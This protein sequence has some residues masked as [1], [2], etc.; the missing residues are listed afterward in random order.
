MN[1]KKI[2]LAIIFGL[3]SLMVLVGCQLDAA[4][5]ASPAPAQSASPAAEA[6]SPAPDGIYVVSNAEDFLA[7]IGPERTICLEA[8]FY[9]L[10]LAESYG[11]GCGENW[12]W[13]ECYD[14]YKLVINGL[15]GL[16]I[17]GSLERTE[18]A[19]QPRYANVLNFENC[20]NITLDSLVLGHTPEPGSCSGGV[21]YLE[22]CSNVRINSGNLYGCGTIG[23]TAINCKA[24]YAADCRIYD[25][26]QNAVLAIASYDVRI[27]NS[28]IHHNGS[29]WCSALFY[30]DNCNGFAIVNCEV[31][32]NQAH[33][34]VSSSYSQQLSILGCNVHTNEFSQSLLN[35]TGYSP[36]VDKCSFGFNG[37]PVVYADMKAVDLDGETISADDLLF[38]EQGKAA[39]SGPRQAKPVELEESVNAEGMREVYVSTVDQFL[40]AIAS[41]TVIKLEGEYFDLSQA[42]DY[43]AYGSDSYYWVNA[44]DGPSLVI[45]GVQNLSIIAE[46]DCTIAAIPRY[47]DVLSFINCENIS[48]RGFTAGHTEE[49]GA[50]SGGVLSFK[51]CRGV[52]IDSCHL[53]GCGILGIHAYDCSELNVANTEIYDCSQGA[54]ALYT[55][56]DAS[57][58]SMDVHDCASPEIALTDSM[59]IDYEGQTL[60]NGHY[61]IID[62]QPQ[63]VGY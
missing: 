62:K 15:S 55:V 59:N 53:Y 4:P 48:L 37:E 11:T 28:K 52:A 47:A 39:Y 49:P 56:T 18:I 7:A 1:I 16:R 10:S 13:E 41:D 32:E 17:V 57:F 24:V 46:S 42:T 27:E 50:C 51:N 19:T 5:A 61:Q 33:Q 14:G 54:I 31:Y 58:E 23:I 35:C 8:G 30:A 36:V 26:S 29:D 3:L 6:V 40:A 9:D 38:M 25:C 12:Y 21:L 45:N 2:C 44:Y 20:K 34:L 22:N 43:G 63:Y 60:K